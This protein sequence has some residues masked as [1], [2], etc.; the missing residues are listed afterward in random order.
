[1]AYVDDGFA[2]LPDDRQFQFVIEMI[3]PWYFNFYASWFRA[4]QASATP[5]LFITYEELAQDTSGALKKTLE[6]L[7]ECR[8]EAQ[9]G[10][11]IARA[12][13]MNTRKNKG[14][15]GRGDRMLTESHKARIRE[16]RRYYP[17]ADFSMI[18]I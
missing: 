18:G 2:D 15:S 11:A 7:G 8:T 16:L 4:N 6:F 17:Q 1:M 10:Q 13:A 9:I 14:V 3:L 5:L 12:A